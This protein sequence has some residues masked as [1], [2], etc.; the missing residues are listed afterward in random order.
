MILFHDMSI[1]PENQR[2]SCLSGQFFGSKC[3]TRKGL[4]DIL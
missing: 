2:S 3:C 1:F 4:L